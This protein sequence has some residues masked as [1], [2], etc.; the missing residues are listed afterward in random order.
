MFADWRRYWRS[1]RAWVGRRGAVGCL[2]FW[3]WKHSNLR[4]CSMQQARMQACTV[5][6]LCSACFNFLILPYLE[7]CSYQPVPPETSGGRFSWCFGQ[8]ACFCPFLPGSHMSALQ[9]R[10]RPRKPSNP[11]VLCWLHVRATKRVCITSWTSVLQ[12]P[13]WQEQHKG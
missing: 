10:T 5:P 9:L 13:L 4:Q 3:G 6:D 8:L 1:K 7:A 2:R 12:P 11:I